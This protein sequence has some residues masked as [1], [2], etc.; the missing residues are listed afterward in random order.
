MAAGDYHALDAQNPLV[1]DQAS[2][3]Q[4]HS[5]LGSLLILFLCLRFFRK[6]R[7]NNCSVSRLFLPSLE[8]QVDEVIP[9]CGT[10]V[11]AIV[12]ANRGFFLSFVLSFF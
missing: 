9:Q 1:G 3:F 11:V 4:L 5:L 2:F 8:L 10:L 12:F 7:R 6:S